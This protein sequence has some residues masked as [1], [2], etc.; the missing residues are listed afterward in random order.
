M[1]LRMGALV[2]AVLAR[3][4]GNSP[5]WGFRLS[6]SC[7]QCESGEERV[8]KGGKHHFRTIR[9]ETRGSPRVYPQAFL[10]GCR[11][12]SHLRAVRRGK[13][14]EFVLSFPTPESCWSRFIQEGLTPPHSWL[15]HW[16]SAVTRRFDSRHVASVLAQ[17][18]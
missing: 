2:I 15:C 1:G 12:K 4:G 5:K 14:W 6:S 16:A 3:P 11:K 18:A 13:G 8:M 7:V 9:E 10:K 17:W